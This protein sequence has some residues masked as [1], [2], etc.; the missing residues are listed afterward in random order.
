MFVNFVGMDSMKIL[1]V[2]ESDPHGV[3]I[4][5]VSVIVVFAALIVLYFAYSIIG[6]IANWKTGSKSDE[7]AAAISLA[8]HE[9]IN[10]STHDK[11]SYVITIRRPH[12]TSKDRDE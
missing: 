10:D 7:I 12:Q 11:E 5:V 9:H 8:L 3:I 2:A 4:T 6:K 1:Q